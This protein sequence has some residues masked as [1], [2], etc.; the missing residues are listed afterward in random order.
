MLL[1]DVFIDASYEC[2]G[3]NV[4]YCRHHCNHGRRNSKDTNPY[5]YINIYIRR[6]YWSFLSKKV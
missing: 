5:P 1:W 3:H 6:L 4:M 2:T